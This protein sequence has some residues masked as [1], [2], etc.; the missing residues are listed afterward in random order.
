[1]R[2]IYCEL[3]DLCQSEGKFDPEMPN[4]PN[5]AARTHDGRYVTIKGG[6]SKP[7]VEYTDRSN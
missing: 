4:T 5:V 3:R 6:I 7:D 1:M 2:S